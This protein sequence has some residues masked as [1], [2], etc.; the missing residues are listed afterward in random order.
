MSISKIEEDAKMK[1]KRS[2]Y[3]IL[4]EAL[5]CVH[6]AGIFYLVLHDQPDG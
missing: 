5:G 6:Q 2:D 4:A 3:R 1:L